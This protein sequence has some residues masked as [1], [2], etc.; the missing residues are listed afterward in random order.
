M[1]HCTRW[2]CQMLLGSLIAIV[3][4]VDIVQ[5]WNRCRSGMDIVLCGVFFK[6]SHCVPVEWVLLLETDCGF[7]FDTLNVC[8]TPP[9]EKWYG[10]NR[11]AGLVVGTSESSGVEASAAGESIVV[12]VHSISWLEQLKQLG[13]FSSHWDGLARSSSISD[14]NIIHRLGAKH[15]KERSVCSIVVQRG[16]RF[17]LVGWRT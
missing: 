2:Y 4:Y 17:R 1:P 3:L 15:S 7:G 16:R 8:L 6:I 5:W 11:R 10:R 14:S 12:N 9:V 13:R